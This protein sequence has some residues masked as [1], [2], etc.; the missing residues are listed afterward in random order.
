MFGGGFHVSQPIAASEL[1]KYAKIVSDWGAE[2]SALIKKSRPK[3]QAGAY[4]QFESLAMKSV[5]AVAW[6]VDESYVALFEVGDRAL[7]WKVNGRPG[8]N[9]GLD[10]DYEALATGLRPRQIFEVPKE[11]GVCVPYAFIRDFHN[12]SR[13]VG[14]TYRFQRHPDVTVLLK[15][16]SAAGP[17]PD[18]PRRDI[19][20][21]EYGSNDFWSQYRGIGQRVVSDWV[22]SYRSTRLAGRKG[23]A[24]FVSITREDGTQDYGYLAVAPGNPEA[25]E[26]TPDLMLYVIRDAKNAKAKGIEPISKEALLE[27]AQTIAASVKRR[28]VQ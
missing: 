11:A 9:S 25:K 5:A 4:M 2:R 26:D 12:T 8:G 20:T 14:T 3:N 15:D 13:V 22:P 24:S 21:A 27:M 28:P 19:F 16:S 18:N 7:L 17:Q 1:E 6:R 23:L 10:S